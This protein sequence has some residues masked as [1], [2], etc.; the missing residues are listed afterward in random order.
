[1]EKRERGRESETFMHLIHQVCSI[2]STFAVSLGVWTEKGC[3]TYSLAPSVWGRQKDR[4]SLRDVISA[5]QF[6][7]AITEA[8][9]RQASQMHHLVQGVP[10]H[11]KTNSTRYE[12]VHCFPPSFL[13]WNWSVMWALQPW[14]EENYLCVNGSGEGEWLHWGKVQSLREQHL[15]AA[16]REGKPRCAVLCYVLCQVMYC[17]Y[18]EGGRQW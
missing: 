10:L 1:M 8:L 4:V 3:W 14:Q 17:E 15:F 16:L 7:T 18:R 11:I 2:R 6:D 9:H 13:S 12:Q 5:L